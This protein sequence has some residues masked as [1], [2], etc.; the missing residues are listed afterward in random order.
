MKVSMPSVEDQFKIPKQPISDSDVTRRTVL[1]GIAALA[2]MV[3]AANAWGAF[4]GFNNT[5]TVKTPFDAYPNRGWE[6]S[7]RDLYAY[8]STFHFLCAPNDTHNCLLTSYVKN[9]VLVRIGPSYGYGKSS[10]TDGIKP[11][12]RWDPRCCQKGLALVRRFYG[13]R[14]V[15][16]PMMREGFKKWAD[17]GFPRDSSTGVIDPKYLKRGEE[18]FVSVAWDTAFDY[19][20]RA[21]QNVAK[22][23]SGK[24]GAK[25][26]ALQG[27][28][29]A[30]IAAMQEAG[31]QS[32]KFRGGM[33]A[34]GATRIFAQYRLANMMAL[35]DRN[36]RGVGP[37]TALGGR[38]WDNYSWHTDLP[39][40]HPQVTGQQTVDWDLNATEHANLIIAWGMNWITTKMPDAHWLT[41]SMLKGTKLIVIAAEYSATS[42]KA[43]HVLIVRPGTTPALAL[44]FAHVIIKENLF[45]ADYLRRATDFPLLVRDDTHELLSA[46]DVF[47]N[48]TLQTLKN[49][50]TIGPNEKPPHSLKQAGPVLPEGLRKEWGDYVV[51]DSATGTFKA[52]SRDH[53]GP[54]FSKLGI[55]P[56]LEGVF[57][58]VLA[59]GT[60]ITARPV[61]HHVKSVI[62]ESYDPKTVSEITN[63]PVEGIYSV[64]RQIAA[65]KEK[66]LMACGMGPNQFFNSDLKDRAIFL[67]GA[68]TRNIGRIGG[69]IGCFAGNYRA[70]YFS[71]LG[72][73]IAEDPFHPKLD[74]YQPL[75]RKGY[76]K[77][78]SVHYWNHG[79]TVLRMGGEL[80]TGKTHIPTPTK[81]IN[82]SNSNSLIGNAKGHYDTVIN[83]LPKCDFVAVGEWWWTASC[84]Y[85]DIVWA[86]DS[87]AEMKYPDSTISVT[88]PF[89]YIFPDTPL[90]RIHDTR[91][92][93]EVAAGIARAMGKLIDDD[94]CEKYWRYI[95]ST[96]QGKTYLERVLAESNISSSYELDTLIADAKQGIPA[97]MMT[98]TY[99]KVGAY[100]QGTE[101]KPW[102]TKTGRLELF[103]GE[104]E[105]RDSG[106][107]VPVHREPID[108]TFY[109]PNVIVA[110]SNPIIA[111]KTPE[112]YGVP[113]SQLDGDTRQARHVVKPWTQVKDT[114]HP[115][116][117]DGFHLIFHT[118]K[119]RHGAHTTASD[120]DIIAVWFGPFGDMHRR[121]KRMP[122]VTEG[123]ADI[124][125]E[126]AKA[127]GIEDG[128][129]IYIDADPHH[130]PFKG[131]EKPEN[132]KAYDMAR[133]M[134]RCRYYPGTP[135]SVV[136]MWHNMHGSTFG[137]RRGHKNNPD[138]LAR[139]PQT[140]YQSMFR[141]GSHQSTTRGYL[142]PTWMTDSLVRKDLIGQVI[143]T[144]FAP[145]VNCPVGAPREA[146]VKI[147]KA[148]DGGLNGVGLWEPAKKG[149]R[150]TYENAVMK[151]YLE[152][153]FVET[154]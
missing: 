52:I 104:P 60:K 2:G 46:S 137:S 85:A 43:D 63:A 22:T 109:E 108:S 91:S 73:Y 15:K 90:P 89:L 132:A 145:D 97:P 120:L 35:L 67:V 105:F 21:M 18:A 24:A 138:G 42:S 116:M 32:L 1:G 38:G 56:A 33:A 153:G 134:A 96:D 39:P 7:Y 20:A 4:S 49:V 27:Y 136:R 128:D 72:N 148:E 47:Q 12:H 13:E 34:L 87:W 41:E 127:L 101:G 19:T 107:R 124:N 82:V 80:L 74:A 121:D 68:L 118:P 65:N 59:D 69:N 37:D 54:D 84:E 123:Y 114:T 3:S 58:V 48:Y 50:T 147:T 45:D 93:L 103:R 140:G 23:Y 76:F 71:G 135:R 106:E 86:V 81:A 26:L 28:D 10:D 40:G 64:A 141:S 78:E 55:T 79:D 154:S 95:N 143:H 102:Y 144:G 31:V 129:Y 131:W 53:V 44:G 57:D 151:K 133:L 99:P 126:D 8:D 9:G 88:N 36:V 117:K 142:K 122:F 30:M 14:R 100:E 98:R 92:D 125:P 110:Q 146:F 25:K 11:S 29:E 152:G 5:I 149:L 77:A 16:K 6:Q 115:L 113:R 51:Y 139:N 17:A 66:T 112:D 70:A 75:K 83:T 94:L 111:P 119:Y 150:P 61:F 130:S 62:M